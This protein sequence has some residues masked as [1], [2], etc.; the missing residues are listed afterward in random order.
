MYDLK[1]LG[2]TS[3]RNQ[4]LEQIFDII[5]KAKINAN[6]GEENQSSEQ[7]LDKNELEKIVKETKIAI[8]KKNDEEKKTIKIK[9]GDEAFYALISTDMIQIAEKYKRD[10]DDVHKIFY[11]VSGDRDKLIK[12]LE[13]QNGHK[14]ELIEDLA[15]KESPESLTFK[16]LLK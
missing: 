10:V 12:V 3:R 13:G 11:Q 4:S 1:D 16:F 6:H 15:L 7:V 9:S 2:Q 14:W 5:E 8:I